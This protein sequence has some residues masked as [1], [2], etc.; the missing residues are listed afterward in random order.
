MLVVKPGGL[1]EKTDFVKN[2]ATVM[3]L[4]VQ[5]LPVSVNKHF[6]AALLD[7]VLCWQV[8]LHHPL[9]DFQT[10][11]RS[12]AN[13]STG[14]RPQ[15]RQFPKFLMPIPRPLNPKLKTRSYP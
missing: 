14:A 13:Q 1:L 12:D 2:V 9:P 6:P 3:L 10:I 15:F 7:V 11:Q 8:S 5:D 4:M